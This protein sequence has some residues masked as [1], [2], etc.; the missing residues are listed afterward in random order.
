MN[1]ALNKYLVAFFIILGGLIAL[2]NS[3]RHP[4]CGNL[5]NCIFF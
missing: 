3:E 4:E 1:E 2:G 5:V